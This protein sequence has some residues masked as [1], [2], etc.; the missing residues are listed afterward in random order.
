[1]NYNQLRAATN[2]QALVNS[3]SCQTIKPSTHPNMMKAS[4]QQLV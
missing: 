2:A 3:F 4:N 1:M